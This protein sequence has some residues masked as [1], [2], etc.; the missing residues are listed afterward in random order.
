MANIDDLIRAYKRFAALPWNKNVSGPERVWMC[1]YQPR[2]E[3]RLRHRLGEFELATKSAGHDW[4]LFDLT[5]SFERW[6]SGHE[7]RE[8]YFASPDDLDLALDEFSEGLKQELRSALDTGGNTVVALLGAGSLF[9]VSSVSSLIQKV[10][11]SVPGR[12]LVFFPG[13][14]EGNNYRLLDARDGWNYLATPIETEG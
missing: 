11:D 9:G 4:L 7:Y 10:A 14:K 13:E 8:D 5:D 2:E 12:L 1:I 6:M 3:R